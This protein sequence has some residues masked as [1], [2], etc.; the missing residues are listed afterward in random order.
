MQ[1]RPRMFLTSV[2]IKPIGLMCAGLLLT[3]LLTLS[4]PVPMSAAQNEVP[5]TPPPSQDSGD[6]RGLPAMDVES[7]GDLD[8]PQVFNGCANVTQI[9][10]A[11]CNALV[12]LYNSTDGSNWFR[13]TNWLETDLP[14][15]WEG[16]IC[17]GKHVTELN[18]S[19]NNLHGTIPP[20]ISQLTRLNKLLLLG[21]RLS[22]IIPPELGQL[23][24][25]TELLLTINELS[26]PIPSELGQLSNL[27][28]LNLGNN[29]L[30]GAI[31]AEL[32]DLSN[33][34]ILWLGINKFTGSIPTQLG[35]LT[36]LIQLDLGRNDLSGTIPP[37]LGGL[38]NLRL[39]FLW[40]NDL[41]GMIPESLGELANLRQLTL[42]ENQI[43]GT[44]PAEL[45]QLEELREL[46]LNNNQLSGTIPESLSGLTKLKKLILDNNQLV[47]SIP[48]A[49]GQMEALEEFIL[50]GNKLSGEIP[51]SLVNLTNLKVFNFNFNALWATDPDLI[52]FLDNLYLGWNAAQTVTP[53]N[54]NVT[55]DVD[56]DLIVTWKPVVRPL[57][58][59]DLGSYQVGCATQSGGPYDTTYFLYIDDMNASQATFSALPDSTY[60]CAVRTYTPPHTLNKNEV[61]SEWSI[62][63]SGTVTGA[64]TVRG[65]EFDAPVIV[66]NFNSQFWSLNAEDANVDPD[67]PVP[68]PSCAADIDP[69]TNKGIFFQ[70][71]VDLS[72]D[73]A[74][75]S[76]APRYFKSRIDPD[77]VDT[78]LAIY[79]NTPGGFVEILCDDNSG[80]FG[81]GSKIV[82]SAFIPGEI[83]T[84]VIWLREVGPDAEG[85]VFQVARTQIINVNGDFT[86]PKPNNPDMPQGWIG[87]NLSNKSKLLCDAVG[88]PERAYSAPCFFQFAASGG[89]QTL[90][91]VVLSADLPAVIRS[92]TLHVSANIK[93]LKTSGKSAIGFEVIYK[94]GKKV[95]RVKEISAGNSGADYQL[96]LSPTVRVQK[97]VKSVRVYVTLAGSRGKLRVDDVKLYYIP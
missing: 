47:G 63:A 16:I 76:G 59:L 72:G 42:S 93:R 62:E 53:I 44:I 40:S 78:V 8:S 25:L 65:D 61:F 96:V 34:T 57:A 90:Q 7:Q 35:N 91:Q 33:L 31:P 79:Q 74:V 24:R 48:A 6:L 66:S 20:Q 27:S 70:L 12:K 68:P 26:G 82:S 71:P 97:A 22:G 41:N 19:N 89:V 75:V 10:K 94:N 18:L 58:Y 28:I 15:E 39:L 51:A 23:S 3:T 4:F 88:Q 81:E 60:Y 87:K 55:V 45:G 73:F 21:N 85:L 67:F 36:N 30:T 84:A 37:S 50:Y 2:H 11:Q 5:L 43:Q 46:F 77:G 69:D 17:T 32:G 80:P 9:P 14:C 92:G 83:Y 95:A 29:Q 49:L 54:V 13:S 38:S 64:V 56:K 52:E 1:P 86:V